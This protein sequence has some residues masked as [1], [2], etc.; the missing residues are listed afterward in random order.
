MTV[1]AIPAPYPTAVQN[2]L[3]GIRRR[4]ATLAA[5]YRRLRPRRLDR[6]AGFFGSRRLASTALA[7]IALASEPGPTAAGA[8]PRSRRVA[9]PAPDMNAMVFT[10]GGRNAR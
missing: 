7:S 6:R 1:E 9:R 2:T 5:D 10:S 8:P 4:L 3:L